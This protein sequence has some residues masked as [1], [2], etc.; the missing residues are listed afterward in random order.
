MNIA[1]HMHVLHDISPLRPHPASP[2][3]T[4]TLRHDNDPQARRL[5]H[6]AP[7]N[8]LQ[9]QPT[10]PRLT[11]LNLRNLIDMLETN[12]A[13]SALD[14]ISHRRTARAR[15]ALLP[16]VVVHRTWDIAGAADLVLHGGHA[17]GGEQ[18]G[19][20]WGSAQRE[21]EGPVGTDGYAGWDGGAGCV[22]GGAGVEFLA[23]IHALHTFTTQCWTDGGRGRRLPCAHYQFDDLVFCYCF[24]R[25]GWV[26][27]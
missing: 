6:H 14:R 26:V 22:V 11:M 3:Q 21:V 5:R 9:A 7:R 25:H 23:E 17:G 2:Q 24:S 10:Q 13:D 12:G 18:E 8:S 4:Q 20:G 27:G 1:A 15:L 19:C 16:L